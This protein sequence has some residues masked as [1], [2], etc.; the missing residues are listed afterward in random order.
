MSF[1]AV[2]IPEF[3][4]AAWLFNA[5]ELMGRPLALLNGMPPQESVASLNSI[6]EASGIAHGM[7]KAQ[8]ETACAARLRTRDEK[9]ERAAF[10]VLLEATA[11][12]SPR[13]Q[14]IAAPINQYA[15]QDRLA[16]SLLIDRSG[17]GT[18][19]GT[20][21]SYAQRLRDE[22]AA[23]GLPARVATAPNADAA[24]ILAKS[25]SDIVCVD[26]QEL[27]E[28][29]APLSTS[30][31]PCD[32][33]T[34][35]V[36]R[37]WGIRTLGQLAAL[38]ADGLI[39]RLGQVGYRLQQLA[40][41]EAP[42]LLA[43]EQEDFALC[44]SLN[45]ESPIDDLERLVYALSRLLADILRKAVDRAYAIRS[46]TAVFALDHAQTHHVRIAPA[47]PT[48]SSDGL[49]RLLALELETHPPQSEVSAVRLE[50]DPAPPQRAQR[51]LFQN[52]FPDPDKTD[53]LLA[54]LRSI[55]GEQ[56]VGSPELANS[57]R[58]DA[59]TM[60]AFRPEP[61]VSEEHPSA[62]MRPALRVLRPA[63]SVRVWLANERPNL[64]FW[65]G[66]KLRIIDL[67]GPWHN[68]G[69]WWNRKNFDCDYWD[70]LTA[71]PTLMLR[72]QQDHTA[73]T[74]NVVGLYD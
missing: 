23:L 12:F 69:S 66:I 35:A 40:C 38:P 72:L 29:L 50:A 39:S 48:Q 63:Q 51:G 24:L 74:W 67:A 60:A 41:G 49:L 42:H 43:P 15:A 6:A 32:A 20:A 27:R 28:S 14:A 53:L 19:F 44:E 70:I 1:A 62:N 11:R 58:E 5:P 52:Q 18:L 36:L 2:H 61:D 68:S 3:P 22:L 34:R 26:Q 37:R 31:L 54:R 10:Q 47:S 13:V 33:K 65:R 25:I 9:E 16:A 55:A 45:L 46:L 7:S 73:K 17:T 4:I 21:Q 71:E 64:L 8:A 56:N 30:V 59:F 57:H